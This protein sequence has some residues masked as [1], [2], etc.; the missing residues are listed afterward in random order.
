[1]TLSWWQCP[2]TAALPLR[3]VTAVIY[4]HK[5]TFPAQRAA[6]EGAA[7]CEIPLISSIKVIG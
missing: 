1:M 2:G 4:G 7:V 5:A 6:P 3:I